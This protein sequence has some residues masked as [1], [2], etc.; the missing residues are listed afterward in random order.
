MLDEGQRREEVGAWR[1]G[2]AESGARDRRKQP[3]VLVVNSGFHAFHMQSPDESVVFRGDGLSLDMSLRVAGEADAFFRPPALWLFGLTAA[4]RVLARPPTPSV[5]LAAACR[6]AFCE[7]EQFCGRSVWRRGAACTCSTRRR[8]CLPI[9]RRRTPA[10]TGC[11]LKKVAPIWAT[12]VGSRG[13][14]A[15]PDDG[16]TDRTH[17]K[18]KSVHLSCCARALFLDDLVEVLPRLCGF[19]GSRRSTAF[20]LRRLL[21]TGASA[22]RARRHNE[23]VRRRLVDAQRHRRRA[24]RDAELLRVLDHG[25]VHVDETAHFAVPRGGSTRARCAPGGNMRLFQVLFVSP[26]LTRK[27]CRGSPSATRLASRFSSARSR[28]FALPSSPSPARGAA[29]AASEAGRERL[30]AGARSRAS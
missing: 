7:P 30:G 29:A 27:P 19:L 16:L 15:V 26:Y 21:R 13:Q 28:F 20:R 10:T 22:C 3:D 5:A 2:R 18:R 24:R 6:G 23:L 8:A 1:V 11:T 4:A 12:A 14:R 25:L 9:R 17:Q